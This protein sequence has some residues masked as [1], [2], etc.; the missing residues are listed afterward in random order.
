MLISFTHLLDLF[1]DCDA[2]IDSQMFVRCNNMPAADLADVTYAKY[3]SVCIQC[4]VCDGTTVS[5]QSKIILFFLICAVHELQ[6][7]LVAEPSCFL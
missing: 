5:I 2:I 7:V 1:V 6:S 4:A 3:T